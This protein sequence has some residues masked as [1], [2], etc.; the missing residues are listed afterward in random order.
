[1]ARQGDTLTGCHCR[2]YCYASHIRRATLQHMPLRRESAK[3]IRHAID[4]ASGSVYASAQ[5]HS[6][7]MKE[8]QPTFNVPTTFVAHHHHSFSHT[9]HHLTQPRNQGQN[10]AG[11]VISHREA[12]QYEN[13]FIADR[14]LGRR[15]INTRFHQLASRV[16]NQ[17]N[18]FMYKLFRQRYDGVP[19]GLLNRKKQC[20]A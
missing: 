19:L 4:M 8:T 7:S 20:K 1:M 5:E 14:W 13:T 15:N 12:V 18:P 6:R 16:W 11:T 2:H 10:N 9:Q 3:T 17:L